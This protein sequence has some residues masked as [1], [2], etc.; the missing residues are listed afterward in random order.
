MR[1]DAGIVIIRARR[2]GLL[3]KDTRVFNA[4]LK[5]GTRACYTELDDGVVSI[6]REFT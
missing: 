5:F 3:I 2:P 4:M 1:G 6:Y